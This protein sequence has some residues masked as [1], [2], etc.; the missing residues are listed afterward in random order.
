MPTLFFWKDGKIIGK[1]PLVNVTSRRP[2]DRD[3]MEKNHANVKRAPVV[4][5][6]RSEFQY[7]LYNILDVGGHEDLI[8]WQDHG[9][10]V[11]INDNERFAEEILKERYG[12][13]EDTMK[14]ASFRRQLNRY[15]F[16]T[17][18]RLCPINNS[19]YFSFWS[20]NFQQGSPELLAK[21]QP[22][23]KKKRQAKLAASKM[24]KSPRT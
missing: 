14:F 12:Y 10:A 2:T 1:A 23:K 9:T 16:N 18:T 11:R 3:T 7:V 19:T 20:E 4:V 15:G 22:N 5:T 21:M 17:E 8:R 24:K 13:G 6:D